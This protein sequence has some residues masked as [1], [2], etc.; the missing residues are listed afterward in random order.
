MLV[1]NNM[2]QMP[3]VASIRIRNDKNKYLSINPRKQLCMS[4]TCVSNARKRNNQGF[5]SR[6]EA[7][8][9]EFFELA[10]RESDIQLQGSSFCKRASISYG[11]ANV[12]NCK[13]KNIPIVGS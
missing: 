9:L 12:H 11:C 8:T 13:I 5:K 10:T 7:V 2:S 6:H 4:G 1:N 3:K